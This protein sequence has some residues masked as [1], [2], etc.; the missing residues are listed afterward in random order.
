MALTGF[1]AGGVDYCFVLL[2]FLARISARS[3]ASL[4]R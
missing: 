3:C 4:L 2:R 1:S